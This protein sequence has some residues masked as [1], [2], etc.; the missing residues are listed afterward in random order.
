VQ[1]EFIFLEEKLKN[2]CKRKP[3]YYLANPGNWG[4]ALIRYGTIKFFRQAGIQYKELTIPHKI[5][6]IKWVK[7]LINRGVL[8]YGGGGAWCKLWN[9]PIDFLN[10][11][12]KYFTNIVVLPSTYELQ[13]SID[14][15][16][17]FCRDFYESKT[18]IPTAIFCHDMAFYIGNIL[19]PKGTGAGY[20]FRTD[21]GS[22]NKFE[23]PPDNNDL[24]PGG[25]HFSDISTFVE[26]IAK[27]EII[28]TDRLHIA[29]AAC[30]LRKPLHFYAG[31]YFKNK[32]I[33]LSSMQNFFNNIW[34]H[35]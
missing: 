30:L 10:R 25:D 8:I 7:P 28:H 26:K 32:A 5:K 19:T 31:S 20:F 27:Y 2:I 15:T 23:I 16:T 3:V 22:L 34:F 33:Y 14:N 11:V 13:Y 18:N 12:K 21:S 24:S 4:D 9:T 35:E 6:W 29:I 17:F 1:K